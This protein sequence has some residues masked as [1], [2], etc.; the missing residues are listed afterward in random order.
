M[1]TAQ[2]FMEQSVQES[3]PSIAMATPSNEEGPDTTAATSQMSKPESKPEKKKRPNFKEN[4]TQFITLIAD[5][6][7]AGVKFGVHKDFACHYSP[8]LEAAFNSDFT[9]GQTQSYNFPEYEAD[10]IRAL[11]E[12]IYTQKISGITSRPIP[13]GNSS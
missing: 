4:P 1:R 12:W 11:V 7:N 3:A 2:T 13:G 8:V 6:D 9:E 10:V 5:K